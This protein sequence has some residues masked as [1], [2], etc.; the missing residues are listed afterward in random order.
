L[1]LDEVNLTTS[2]SGLI[3]VDEGKPPS[4]KA[5]D[6]SGDDKAVNIWD[7]SWVWDITV[8]ERQMINVP[9]T[10]GVYSIAKEWEQINNLNREVKNNDVLSC[11]LY[12][13]HCCR[14]GNLIVTVET[15]RTNI[16]LGFSKIG[17]VLSS[18]L[19]SQL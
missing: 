13:D 12:F 18:L 3:T 19:D 4:A 17:L 8:D 10:F 11:H 1:A 9:S 7:S 15:V 16:V 6:D 5:N 14:G 2:Q